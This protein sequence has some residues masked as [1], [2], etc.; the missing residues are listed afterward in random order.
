MTE[1]EPTVGYQYLPVDMEY[2]EEEPTDLRAIVFDKVEH[3]LL[4]EELKVRP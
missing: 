1:D 3:V 2:N 4:Q